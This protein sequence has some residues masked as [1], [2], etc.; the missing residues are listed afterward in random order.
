MKPF[1]FFS[2]MLV[3][4]VLIFQLSGCG[5]FLHP[6]RRGQRRV[7]RIDPTIAVLDGLGLLLFIVPGVIAFAVDI[8]NGTLYFPGPRRRAGSMKLIRVRPGDL[9]AGTI[10]RIVKEETGVVIRFDRSDLEVFALDGKENIQEMIA[11]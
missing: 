10:Q 2:R 8:T 6:E 7:G 9:N 11:W 4:G 1:R 5:F 3:L